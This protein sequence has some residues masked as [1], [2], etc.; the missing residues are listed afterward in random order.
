MSLTDVHVSCGQ[1]PLP[2][3]APG[4]TADASCVNER[5]GVIR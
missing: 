1:A 3:I 5:R 2:Y 4:L